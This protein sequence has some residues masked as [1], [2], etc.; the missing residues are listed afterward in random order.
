[1]DWGGSITY[2]AGTALKGNEVTFGVKDADRLQHLCVVGR[3]DSGRAPLLARMAL[4]DIERNVGTVI[5]DTIGV[6]TQLVLERADESIKERLVF[7]DP[8]DAE[9]PYSWNPLDEFRHLAEHERVSRLSDAIASIYH[10]P[11]S[12]LTDLVAKRSYAD[13]SATLL[14]LHDVITESDI[15]EEHF[16]SGSDE[17]A[18]LD[19]AVKERADDASYVEEH[20]R[21]IAKDSLV[22]NL[23]GQRE[24]K[25][26]LERLS[27]GGVLVVD[28]SR[29]RMFPTR[30]T[31]LIRSFVHAL[32][33]RAAVA[34]DPLSLYLFDGLRYLSED[35]VNTIFKEHAIACT[36]SDTL[37]NDEDKALREKTV[38][39]C[40]SIAAFTPNPADVSIVEH[41]FY[42]YV[43]PDELSKL[44]DGEFVIALAIDSVRSRPFFA[45]LLPLPERKGMSHQDLLVIS[46]DRYTANRITVDQMFKKAVEKEKGKGKGKDDDPGSFSDA[47]RSIF[48][49]RA[50]ASAAPGAPAEAKTPSEKPPEKPKSDDVKKQE[51]QTPK[52]I[53]EA[54]LRQMLYVEPVLA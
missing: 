15:R 36:L 1:M 18:S 52:E 30:M 14:L 6:L 41:M 42:P 49:K 10:I 2:L 31:P 4:Q 5:I 24:S 28:M 13:A 44:D 12:S 53:A 47:F 9:F 40:G 48:T 32:R 43:S 19:A 29:I 27:N 20:G 34:K 54:E 46:R 50:G 37:Y 23:L 22:R 25:F 45:K 3:Q 38:S 51:P 8:A 21:Y 17:R 35:D 11:R 26:T 16:P 33:A 39:K 7:L